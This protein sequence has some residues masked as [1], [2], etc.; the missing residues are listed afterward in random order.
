MP[1]VSRYRCQRWG[2]HHAYAIG[3]VPNVCWE[4]L[5]GHR[6]NRTKTTMQR[7]KPPPMGSIRLRDVSEAGLICCEGDLSRW[8][9]FDV[10]RCAAS[11]AQMR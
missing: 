9:R 4:T 11:R 3:G 1:V 10:S 8:E 7:N 2:A 5:V 6:A